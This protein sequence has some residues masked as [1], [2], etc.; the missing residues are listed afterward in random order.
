MTLPR[1]VAWLLEEEEALRRAFPRW[2][3]VDVEGLGSRP[4][5]GLEE[6]WILTLGEGWFVVNREGAYLSWVGAEGFWG[7]LLVPPGGAL[8]RRA[9]L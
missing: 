2:G 7:W 5:W 1:W 3:T 9:P 8:P 6:E 4:F